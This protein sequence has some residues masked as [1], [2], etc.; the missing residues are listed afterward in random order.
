M[1]D[2]HPRFS[3]FAVGAIAMVACGSTVLIDSVRGTTRT[4][5]PPVVAPADVDGAPAAGI[6]FA[7]GDDFVAMAAVRRQMDAYLRA[8]E[9]PPSWVTPRTRNGALTYTLNTSADDTATL[10]FVRRPEMALRDQA[11]ALPTAI[12]GQ[13]RTVLTVSPK[14]I[15]LA[16]L[17]H[18]RLSQ[19]DC[20]VA[21]LREHVGIRQNIVAWA[22][23]LNWVWPDGGS[24]QWNTRYWRRGTPDSRRPLHEAV[25]DAFMAQERY[26]IGCYTAIKLVVLQGVLDY[27]RRVVP[28][29]A[30]LRRVEA[31][32]AADGEPLVGVEPGAMWFFEAD[33]S[34]A[35]AER[36][37]KL[38]E[39]QHGVAA[40]NFVPGD[41]AYLLNTDAASYG[42]TGYEG[43]NTIYLGRDRFSDYYN[44]HGHA[45][46]FRQKLNEVY[47][48]RHGV[49]SRTRDAAKIRPLSEKELVALAATPE[50]G[51]LLLS[52]RGTVSVGPAGPR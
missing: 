37:G 13:T 50:A 6:R 8:E 31:Q 44:D 11:V 16:L 42:K 20:S 39:L 33:Y 30:K 32:L 24:A 18:G 41:W 45:Y 40:D 9:I 29:A 34:P 49:F 3:R 48:W 38:I 36:P 22:E 4:A 10:D 28:D 27:H 21:A 2:R 43:S 1:I 47:Q 7:C 15:L 19:F 23:E 35:D 14:E 25:N 17:Q 5:L 46:S 52:Y 26:R 12:G 51:G